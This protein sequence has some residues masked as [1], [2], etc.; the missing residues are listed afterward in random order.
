MSE[1]YESAKGAIAEAASSPKVA[2]VVAAGST[3]AGVATQLDIITGW[4]GAIASGLGMCTAA[5]VLAIQVIK[6]LRE[7]RDDQKDG[8]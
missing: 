6:L 2:T 4:T 1:P 5:V 3:S 7:W 8:G